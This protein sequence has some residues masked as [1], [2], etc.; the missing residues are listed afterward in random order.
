MR[1]ILGLDCQ[2]GM[3]KNLR[4]IDI[5]IMPLYNNL[6]N[7]GKCGF[8][9]LQYMALGIPSVASPI[10][11]NKEIISHS[12]NGFL[13]HNLIDWVNYIQILI[14]NHKIYNQIS[15][16]SR[17]KVIE[18]YSFKRYI[19]IIEKLLEEYNKNKKKR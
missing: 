6:F 18:S 15:I 5:G 17:K 12:E 19:P 9:L 2:M 7:R 1:I 10:G 11:V 14:E 13:A 8:K 16:N 3:K 4:L